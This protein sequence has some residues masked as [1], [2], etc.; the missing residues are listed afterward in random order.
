MRPGRKGMETHLSISANRLVEEHELVELLAR[1]AG[2]GLHASGQEKEKNSVRRRRDR[3]RARANLLKLDAASVDVVVDQQVGAHL[4]RRVVELLHTDLEGKKEKEE[5][6]EKREGKK[7]KKGKGWKKEERKKVHE[8]SVAL[9]II[10]SS[11]FACSC[12]RRWANIP[13]TAW[14]TRRDCAVGRGWCACTVREQWHSF[15]LWSDFACFKT[16]RLL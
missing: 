3:E 4:A 8:E 13:G 1:A 7:R 15:F 9:F 10:F 2:V 12:V 11:F 16:S 5:E 6:R 14:G